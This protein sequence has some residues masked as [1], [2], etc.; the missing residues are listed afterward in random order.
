MC[1]MSLRESM[2]AEPGGTEWMNVCKYDERLTQLK[3]SIN[4]CV[5][6]SVE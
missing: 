2:C 5:V 3:D 1:V 6:I 4:P